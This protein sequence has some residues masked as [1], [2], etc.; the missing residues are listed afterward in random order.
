M[1]ASGVA[2][3]VK[4]EVAETLEGV[5]C[6]LSNHEAVPGEPI[7]IKVRVDPGTAPGTYNLTLRAVSEGVESTARITLAVKEVGVRLEFRQHDVTVSQG[8]AVTV[9]LSVS[10]IGPFNGTV[11]LRVRGAPRGVRV[12]VEPREVILP[13][14]AEI[15]IDVSDDS[16]PGTYRLT[17][18]ASWD[19]CKVSSDLTLEVAPALE[20]EVSVAPRSVKTYVGERVKVTVYVALLRGEAREVELSVSN[21]PPGSSYTL[22]PSR[23]VPPGESTLSI[24]VGS[25]KGVYNVT[26]VA[27]CGNLERE[28]VLTLEVAE[29]R[30]VIATATYGSELSE[31]V[32]L[33]RT[34]RDEVVLA[35]Y[36][37]R[38]FYDLF[39]V[40]Y[41]SWSPQAAKLVSSDERLRTAVRVALYPLLGA[42]AIA[43][44]VASLA[45]YNPEAAAYLAGTVSAALIG[46][47]YLA[48]P[49]T[50][51]SLLGR[52]RLSRKVLVYLF[53]ATVVVLVSCLVALLLTLDVALSF[54]TLTY[55]ALVSLLSACAVTRVIARLVLAGA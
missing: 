28:A 20:F 49:F 42:L 10:P 4:L 13:A 6:T 37:G 19:D 25:A 46:A 35:S 3:P 39:N 48:P 53:R 54:L 5:R 23:L 14:S 1:N 17:V 41:Y 50:L 26:V 38:R 2:L 47:F 24:D 21:L 16:A 43:A 31:E 52:W 40:L 22:N 51:L 45:A 44:R 32:R 9:P 30:C 34:F 12:H 11:T 8:R 55:V 27:R 29:K 18:E 15:R 7:A 36:S 33:I